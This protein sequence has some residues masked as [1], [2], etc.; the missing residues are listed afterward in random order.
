MEYINDFFN[1]SNNMNILNGVSSIG[2]LIA[3]LVALFTLRLLSRQ[4]KN[5]QR[6]NVTF[7]NS[8]FGECFSSD[9]KI[10]KTIW[11]SESD[12]ENEKP[13]LSSLDFELINVGVGFAEDVR[14]NEKFNTKAA[15]KFIKAIDYDNEFEFKVDDSVLRIYLNVESDFERI[16]LEKPVRE[17]GN[18]KTA[19]IT[20]NRGNRYVF[21]DEYLTF[22]SCFGYLKR[23]HSEFLN[24]E[25]FPELQMVLTFQDIDGKKYRNK[26]KC[27]AFS[28]TEENYI[29]T[30]VKK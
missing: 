8:A 3:A 6:P 12:K 2:A 23:K 18:F 28:V 5:A 21:D 13:I 16:P 22:I 17:L 29:F 7:G 26:Y 25:K 14:L 11:W 19:A 10:L 9:D 27:S 20:N 24:L 1:D 30:I 15:I 4:H